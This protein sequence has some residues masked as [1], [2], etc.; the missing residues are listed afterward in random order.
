VNRTGS[1][2]NNYLYRGEQFDAD[3]GLYYLRARYYSP[4]TGRFLTRDP[5]G[6]EILAP[7]KLHK[8][9]YAGADPVNRSDPSGKGFID[10]ALLT[11]AVFMFGLFRDSRLNSASR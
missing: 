9:S 4:I 6:R 2:P 8:Y 10:R 3:L 7:E 1:T 5:I 11:A